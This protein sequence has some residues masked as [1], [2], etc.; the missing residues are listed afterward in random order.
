MDYSEHLSKIEYFKNSNFAYSLDA[1]TGVINR[2]M[3][4]EYVDYLA[5]RGDNFSLFL[6]DVDN[7]KNVNDNYGHPAGDTVLVRIANY[8]V[9]SVGSVGVVG[10]YGG[11][12]FVIV[13]EG[14]SEYDEVWK[15]GHDIDMNIGSLVFDGTPNFSV[16]VSIGIARCPIDAQSYDDLLTISD[17]ALYRAKMKGRNCFIIYL[18]EKHAHISLKKERDKRLTSMQ[19]V[20]NVFKDMTAHGEDI[21]TAINVVFEHLATYFMYD[22][23]CI[24]TSKGLNFNFIHALSLK[25][26]FEPLDYNLLEE[27]VNPAGNIR[28]S[29]RSALTSNSFA[30]LFKEY[31]KQNLSSTLYS[32]ISAYGRNYGFIRIDTANTARIWQNMEVSIV[33]VVANTIGMLLHYQNKTLEDLP[34]VPDCTVGSVKH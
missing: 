24:E 29:A 5:Q 32:R 27:N 8:L 10:R 34:D 1:L 4:T 25:S 15:Y 11:D 20:Q 21:A 23:I 6:V 31:K 3:M 22:H 28:L 30:H 19:I 17:K 18:P 14:V 33:M 12:E 9:E 16:T 13:L 26:E 7:F 2:Q